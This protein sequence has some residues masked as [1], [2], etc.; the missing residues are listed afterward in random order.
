M[1]LA[2]LDLYFLLKSLYKLFTIYKIL[3]EIIY[4]E[5]LKNG[6]IIS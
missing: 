3:I 6:G 2:Y 1:I 4:N 5:Y